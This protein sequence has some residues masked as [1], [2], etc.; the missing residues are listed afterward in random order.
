MGN[1]LIEDNHM[2]YAGRGLC[3][4]RPDKTEAAHIKG[5]NHENPAENYVIR[6]N[7]MVDSFNML[8]HIHASLPGPDGGDSMPRLENNHF[9]GRAGELF[10]VT[11]CRCGTRIPYTAEIAA[12]LGEKSHDDTFWFIE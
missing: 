11:A 12:Y 6:N 8:V 10:G 4:Q 5:W 3:A 7:L 1:L 9:A 2:W